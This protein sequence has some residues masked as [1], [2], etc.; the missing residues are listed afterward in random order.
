MGTIKEDKRTK[1]HI[2]IVLDRSGSMHSIR[3]ATVKAFNKQVETLHKENKE[4]IDTRVSLITF[5]KF[6]DEPV[7]FDTSLKDL[8]KITCE[9]YVPYSA[10]ALNDS[11]GTTAFRLMDL[12]DYEET[13]FLMISITDGDENASIFL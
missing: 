11:I 7:F 4:D 13:K 12:E 6:V 3:E 5:S 2:A 10:T 9:N 1:L 8:K